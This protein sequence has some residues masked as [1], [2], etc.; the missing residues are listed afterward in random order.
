MHQRV[1]PL[2]PM[3]APPGVQQGDRGQL[4]GA[5]CQAMKLTGFWHEFLAQMGNEPGAQQGDVTVH[6]VSP[7]EGASTVTGPSGALEAA[8]E[9]GSF[10][11]LMFM[12]NGRRLFIPA[13]NVAGI[14]DTAKEEKAADKPPRG[15]SSASSS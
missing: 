12:V 11:G 9:A 15:R 14:V 8:A 1:R 6:L 10:I 13:G 5:D 7:I 3:A 4:A 2:V